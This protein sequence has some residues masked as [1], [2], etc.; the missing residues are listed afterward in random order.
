MAI[1]L[2]PLDV[3]VFRD[4]RPF[5]AG[6]DHHAKCVFPPSP[7]TVQGALRS[8]VLTE[9]CGNLD[10]YAGRRHGDCPICGP[11]PYCPVRDEIGTPGTAG[12]F[13]LRSVLPARRE[14]G[15]I[16]RYFAL[17]RHV[18]RAKRG[19]SWDFLRPLEDPGPTSLGD[20]LRVLGVRGTELVEHPDGWVGAP[21]L[22]KILRGEIP[23][24]LRPVRTRGGDFGEPAS[25]APAE[26]DEWAMCEEEPRVGIG[27]KPGRKTAEPGQFFVVDALRLREGWGLAVSFDGLASLPG[28]ALLDIGGEGRAARYET[29]ADARLPPP[30]ASAIEKE[31]RFLL[32]LV[33][34]ALFGG[35]ASRWTWRPGFL[36]QDGAGTVPGGHTI[37]RLVAAALGSPVRISGWEL[38]EGDR[39]GRPR[40]ARAAVPAGSV[41]FFEIVDGP[42]EPVL[43]LHGKAL[44]DWGS[45]F[46]FGLALVGRWLR[47]RD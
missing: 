6:D 24:T 36:G 30:P 46:G 2:E 4:G 29:V 12:P 19:A 7:F 1:F 13:R 18:V 39:G 41:Y 8:K 45:D 16:T 37:V 25:S 38:G 27:L 9:H 47:W 23:S 40:P 10:K 34:P 26:E 22:E 15:A 20:G 32:Y 17:P 28:A 3:W 14:S 21:A 5:S 31:R 42:V 33:M 35:D 11:A 44:T 43:A